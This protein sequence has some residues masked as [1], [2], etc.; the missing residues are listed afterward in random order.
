MAAIHLIVKFKIF[1]YI[2]RDEFESNG[3]IVYTPLVID[4]IN[5]SHGGFNKDSMK[6]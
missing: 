2:S 4:A 6:K 5:N 1:V 3:E